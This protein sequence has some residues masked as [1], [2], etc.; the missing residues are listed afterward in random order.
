MAAKVPLS[1]SALQDA[2]EREYHDGIADIRKQINRSVFG[3]G[4]AHKPLPA[5]DYSYHYQQ[6]DGIKCT[7]PESTPKEVKKMSKKELQKEVEL[8]QTNIHTLYN[9]K[10]RQ[11]DDLDAAKRHFNAELVRIERE[12]SDPK[13]EKKIL[14]KLRDGKHVIDK[15]NTDVQFKR[16]VMSLRHKGLVKDGRH[17]DW[18]E[19]IMLSDTAKDYEEL[20]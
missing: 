19:G 6:Q 10:N 20:L 15:S 7:F 11:D 16:A 12:S 3:T 4:S 1:H 2:Y 17:P 5:C 18:C 13:V 14:A 8:L 9:I